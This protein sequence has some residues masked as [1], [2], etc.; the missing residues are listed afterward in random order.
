VILWSNVITVLSGLSIVN[1]LRDFDYSQTIPLEKFE[2]R[3]LQA[4]YRSDQ[5]NL[6]NTVYQICYI[7]YRMLILELLVI[8]PLSS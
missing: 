3:A 6:I 5:S 7:N 2:N 8:A 4:R 1:G